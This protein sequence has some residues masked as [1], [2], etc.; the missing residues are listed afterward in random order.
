MSVVGALAGTM[1]AYALSKSAGDSP[2][3]RATAEQL[4]LL[5]AALGAA[6]PP[7]IAVAGSYFRL[8][9]MAGIAI[10]VGALVVTYAGI[11]IPQTALGKEPIFPVPTAFAPSHD[12]Q[13]IEECEQSLCITVTPEKLHCSAEACDSAVVVE[14][15]GKDLLRVREIEI[16]DDESHRFSRDAGCERRNLSAGKSCSIVISVG[17]GPDERATLVIHQNLKGPATVVDLE[18]DP[19]SVTGADLVL[20]SVPECEADADTLTVHFEVQ[21]SGVEAK[22]TRVRL[23]SDTGIA[24]SRN[25]PLGDSSKLSSISVDLD[26]D[27]YG[28]SHALTLSVDSEDQIGESDESNNSAEL[29]VTLPARPEDAISVTCQ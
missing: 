22:Q 6:I 8:R 21:V 23:A 3:S 15:S 9:L 1:V 10:A 20:A 4:T 14:N 29:T 13:P 2:T 24:G 7:M 19:G 16:K 12:T 28:T 26:P 5:G 11:V 27:D 25:I 17:P 18:A